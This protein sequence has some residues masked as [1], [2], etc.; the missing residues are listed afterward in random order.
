MD[1]VSV[2]DL[3]F[4]ARLDFELLLIHFLI[5]YCQCNERSDGSSMYATALV[6]DRAFSTESGGMILNFYKL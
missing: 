4:V 5:F 2:F 3:G 6:K 1:Q